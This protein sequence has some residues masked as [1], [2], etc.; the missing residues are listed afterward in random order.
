LLPPSTRNCG[1]YVPLDINLDAGLAI[2]VDD[3]EREVLH[4]GLDILV[5]EF[6]TDQTLDIE[7]STE[8]VRGVCRL[9]V[10]GSLPPIQDRSS[11]TLVLRGV[12]D[13]TFLIGPGDI[14]RS[15]T[16]TLVVDEDID[17]STL[18]DTNTG[19]RGSQIDTNDG[20]LDLSLL[21]VRRASEEGHGGD[22]GEE[23]IEE[24]RPGKPGRRSRV[25]VSRHGGKLWKCGTVG[26]KKIRRQERKKTRPEARLDV[27]EAGSRRQQLRG[28]QH[29]LEEGMGYLW[30]KRGGGLK[31]RKKRFGSFGCRF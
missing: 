25:C 6:T 21:R 22:E 15:D 17:V 26:M 30:R 23:E 12:T 10:S 3:L 2:A 13:Q 9:L 29:K 18:H 4:V 7:D 5:R 27:E 20:A 19:V 28:L 11:L 24:G 1:K 14:R 16:V 8:G 31:K